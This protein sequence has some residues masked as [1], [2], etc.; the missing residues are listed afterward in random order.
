MGSQNHRGRLQYRALFTSPRQ[1]YCPHCRPGGLRNVDG[2]SG[3]GKL[4]GYNTSSPDGKRKRALLFPVF[5]HKTIRR[6]P[7]HHKPETTNCLGQIQEIPDG[8]DPIRNP[9]DRQGR[10]YVHPRPKKGILPGPYPSLIPEPSK[11]RGQFTSPDLPLS[12]PV[13]CVGLSSQNLYK[14]GGR[15]GGLPKRSGYCDHSI[16]GRLPTGG[17]IQRSAHSRQNPS[18][19]RN[20]VPWL[21]D[22]LG[23]VGPQARHQKSI[24]RSPPRLSQQNILATRADAEDCSGQNPRPVEASMFHKR[25]NGSLGPHDSL[26]PVCPLGPIPL[27]V[28][29]ERNPRKVGQKS[30]VARQ[31][32]K[33]ARVKE[34]LRWWTQSRNLQ[35]GVQWTTSAYVVV[36]TDASAWGWGAHIEGKIFQG[37]W[38][39]GIRTRSSNFRELFAVWE[40]LRRNQ[41]VLKNRHV[42]ILSD[43]TTAVAFLKHQGGTR[44]QP[45]Q[46]LA[47]KIFTWAERTVRSVTAVHLEGSQNEVADYLSRQQIHPT[48]WE[49]NMEI[50]DHLCQRWGTPTIDLFASRKNSKVPRFYS[51]NPTDHPE[52]V[53]VLSQT[54]GESL[55]YA[56]PP[57]ALIPAVLRKIRED[58]A[59]V[60]LIVPYWPRRSWFPLLG[61]MAVENP[62]ELPLWK[63]IIHQGPIRLPDPARLHLSAWILRGTS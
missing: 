52:G 33:A 3:H 10:R 15:G 37:K 17:K 18:N 63:D 19:Y 9:P 62:V 22:Q 57:L 25:G 23:E 50:F 20:G 56:F 7:Y 53:D 54:W 59:R 35:V 38:P 29:T 2:S 60:M 47:G 48:E 43:N 42:C 6:G 21:G 26:H 5:N 32:P 34:S 8:I 61:A 40:A 27:E 44:H 24:P 55:S 16:P 12:V 11:V 28:V 49:L 39:A 4:R 36:T 51:L 45:L 13:S 14:I 1:I 30:G 58:Q 41:S 31:T 46:A